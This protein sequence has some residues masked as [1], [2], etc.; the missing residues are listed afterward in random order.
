M[1]QVRRTQAQRRQTAERGILDAA[2]TVISERGINGMSFAEIGT[3]SGYSRGITSH[4]FGTK[5][6]LLVSL[7]RDVGERF[8][9][10]LRTPIYEEAKGLDRLIIYINLYLDRARTRPKV[11]RAL[12][13]MRAESLT[14]PPP[15]QKAVQEA[16][17]AAFASLRDM[18]V[19][20]RADGSLRKEIDIDA[21]AGLI[22]GGLRGIVGQYLADPDTFD[23]DATA[24]AFIS[25]IRLSVA[26]H[27]TE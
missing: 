8:N 7:L 10:A 19:T 5:E 23:I 2:M 15:F 22:V 25:A 27:P 14:A 24:K 21:H 16:N 9:D 13:L 26:V 12:Q 3:V 11:A 4:Y 6:N 20:A 17:L 1:I 18:L